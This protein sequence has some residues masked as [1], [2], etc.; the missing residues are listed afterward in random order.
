MEI[1]IMHIPFLF[2]FLAFSFIIQGLI[3]KT[4]HFKIVCVILS[5]VCFVL[6]ISLLI[7]YGIAF[8]YTK[9]D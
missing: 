4:I 2:G 5:L 1:F 7:R 6:C 3:V 8:G 9:I